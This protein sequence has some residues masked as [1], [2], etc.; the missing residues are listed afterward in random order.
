MM[1]LL[2]RTNLFGVRLRSAWFAGAIAV[3]AG[4]CQLSPARDIYVDNLGGDD[5]STG[6]S[7][8]STGMGTGPVRTIA[9]AL[10]LCMPG[11]SIVL[12]AHPEEPY[13]ETITLSGRY[14]S[15]TSESPVRI[16]GNGAVLDGLAPVVSA[17]WEVAGKDLYAVT[18]RLVNP[19]TVFFGETQAPRPLSSQ[20]VSAGKDP[21][22]GQWFLQRG[23]IFLKCAA[24]GSPE[25]YRPQIANLTVGVTLVDV[26]DVE[27]LDLTVR[28][29]QIDG[30]N[31]HDNV[32][33]TNLTRVTAI[34]C[35]R[36][37]ISIGGASRVL[38]DSCKCSDNLEAQL[39]M[40]GYCEVQ[41]FDNTFGGDAKTAIQK[42]GGKIV[43][44]EQEADAAK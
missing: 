44:P 24:H 12:A 38:V 25:L 14:H 9:K 16:V 18:P 39:R 5:R 37:G 15:G 35:G 27:I 20:E 43:E 29:F 1:G 41:L 22:A 31:A 32:T 10:R 34:G 17:P 36:S 7:L 2:C 23:Q 13:R 3:A 4:W 6:R 11:D 19:Q 8:D 42:N 26:H 30:I 21:A 40:E 28:G 33:R